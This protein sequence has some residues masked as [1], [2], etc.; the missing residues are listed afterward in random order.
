MCVNMISMFIDLLADLP[1]YFVMEML[2]AYYVCCIYS[3][4][5][6]TRFYHESK[7]YNNEPKGA[8]R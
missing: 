3:S 8:G 4:A 1:I 5:L 6:Q 2:S 7:Q